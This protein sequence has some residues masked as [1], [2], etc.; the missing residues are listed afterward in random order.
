MKHIA[1]EQALYGPV[2]IPVV[3]FA[4]PFDD[5]NADDN[6]DDEDDDDKDDDEDEDD[7]KENMS[8]VDFAACKHF[9]EECVLNCSLF[10]CHPQMRT[11]C[12]RLEISLGLVGQV[13][14]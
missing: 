9:A 4:E 6:K 13:L 14:P 11:Q 10:P 12:R 2:G 8:K 7:N 3:D 1:K 5:D